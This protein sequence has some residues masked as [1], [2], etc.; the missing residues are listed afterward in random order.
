MSWMPSPVRFCHTGVTGPASDRAGGQEAVVAIFEEGPARLRIL[1]RD[2]VERFA[3]QDEI[4]LA[5]AAEV[6][7][8][9][10]HIAAESLRLK[11]AVAVAAQDQHVAVVVADEQ[12]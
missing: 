6:G 4:V 8:C 5:V 7:D 2:A 1:N 12:V 11:R 9:Q 3:S 10:G